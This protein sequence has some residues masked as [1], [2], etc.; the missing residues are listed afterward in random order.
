MLFVFD[1]YLCSVC[2]CDVFVVFVALLLVVVF[3]CLLCD[4]CVVICLFD[5]MLAAMFYLFCD[6]AVVC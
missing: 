2:C 5:I 4:A 3:V 6:V 1:C